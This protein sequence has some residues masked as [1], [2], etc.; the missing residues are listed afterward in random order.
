MD[1]KVLYNASSTD[2]GTS[3]I[4]NWL[5]AGGFRR[6][7]TDSAGASCDVLLLAGYDR[8]LSVAESIALTINPWQLFK[9]RRAV[10][11]ASAAAG[12]THPTLSNARMGSMTATGGVPKV[13]YAF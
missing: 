7:G 11:H 1:G 2:L 8:Q 12:Y 6:G 4:Y 5:V 13:D 3:T 9:P 10:F